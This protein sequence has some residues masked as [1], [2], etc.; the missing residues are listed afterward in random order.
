MNRVQIGNQLVNG[1]II[2]HF[3]LRGVIVKVDTKRLR[4][5]VPAAHNK[6]V[7]PEEK[8]GGGGL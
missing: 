6:L 1:N 4:A 3:F 2:S 8:R 5:H 7:N